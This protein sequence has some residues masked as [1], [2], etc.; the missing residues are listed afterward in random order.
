MTKTRKKEISEK[1][2]FYTEQDSIDESR[3][4]FS[5]DFKDV[6]SKLIG[7]E[8]NGWECYQSLIDQAAVLFSF[9]QIGGAQDLSDGIND[10]RIYRNPLDEI[11]LKPNEI[12]DEKQFPQ[13]NYKIQIDFLNQ[14]QKPEHNEDAGHYEWVVKQIS[15]LLY[16]LDH[17]G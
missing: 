1:I 5:I 17:S 12:F 2:R 4:H 6:D 9:E 10:F 15:T 3:G 13:G 11:Y 8:G 16:T 7:E 14:L